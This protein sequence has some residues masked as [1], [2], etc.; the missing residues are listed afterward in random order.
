M[1]VW[2]EQVNKLLPWARRA[3][4]I[5]VLVA[6]ALAGRSWLEAREARIHLEATLAAQKQIIDQASEREKQRAAELQQN[7]AEIQAL[8]KQVQTPQ[9]VI[10]EIAKY[11]PP[12]PQPI[13]IKL[14]ETKP[15]EPPPPATV[16]VPQQDLKPI[17]DFLQDCRAC[18][19]QLVAA[20][21]DLGDE[22]T[23]LAAVTRERDAAVKAA[24]GGGF[25]VRLRRSAKWFLIGG[26]VGAAAVAAA[27]R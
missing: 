18:K 19:L 25:W 26:A 17:F 5:A 24:R 13:E 27:H 7:L 16:T 1:A 15:G 9:Q 14:P 23:K 10:R 2:P 20:Q 6:A 22:H 4:V 11:G 8:K 21:Q 12:L 3:L